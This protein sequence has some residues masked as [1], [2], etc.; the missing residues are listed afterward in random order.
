MR[1]FL[2]SAGKGQRLGKLTENNS[3]CLLPVGNKSMIEHWLY[4]L[5]LYHITDVLINTHH[6]SDKVIAHCSKLSSKYRCRTT[7]TYEKELLGTAKT[8][9]TNRDFVRD[10]RYFLI[11]YTDTWMQVDLKEMLKFQKRHKGMGTIGL[12]KPKSLSDQGSVK[13]NGRKILEIEEKSLHPKGDYAFAGIMIG[14]TS[15]FRFYND[16]MIDLVRDWLPVIKEGLN[17]FFI[18]GL[19]LDI[20]TPER[21]K[22]AHTKISSL[23]LKSL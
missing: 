15:M 13:V 4:L 3:K 10:D 16:K 14:C 1:C 20:G 12:Y 21:Y 17:P 8:I 7:F 19:V 22:E 6:C 23:G 9:S 11:V 18:K 2:L 5:N